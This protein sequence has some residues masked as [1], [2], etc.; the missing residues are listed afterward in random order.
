MHS[1]H[2]V[3]FRSFG[4]PSEVAEIVAMDPSEPAEDEVL[5]RMAFAPINPADVN[6]M[7]G[8]YGKVPALPAFAGNEGVGRIEAVGRNVRNLRAGDPVL[9]LAPPGIWRD[10]F[11][12]PA[13]HVIPLPA[14]LD[15]VQASM[16]RVNPA[17]ALLLLTHFVS[18]DP[19]DWII[20]NAANSAVGLAVIQLARHFGWKTLN[21]VRR[22][23]AA[24][25]CRNFGAD[26]VVL[27]SEP[28]FRNA[29]A[30]AMGDA[31]P[32][33]A[34]NA[35]GGDSALKL[36]DLLAPKGSHVTFGAMSRQKL[37]LPNRFLI[38]KELTF[39]GFWVSRHME[40]ISATEVAGIFQCLADLMRSGKLRLPVEKIYRL[41]E[42]KEALHRAQQPGRSG[43]VL[44]QFG[45]TT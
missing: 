29:A 16:L 34:L 41:A 15:L 30:A 20:Q 6:F 38:F 42:L 7:E 25:M 11:T 17:T 31:E 12:L 35:V 26:A 23:E 14:D 39:T 44:L 37:S 45:G 2:G 36:A 19:G 8:T 43:K 5:V 27:E 3:Q 21:L 13:A 1:I 4:P 28:D 22:P 9:P 10:R 18:L 32:R 24:E 40:A 33:L